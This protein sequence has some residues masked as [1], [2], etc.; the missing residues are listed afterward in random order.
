MRQPPATHC[1]NKGL[2]E[3]SSYFILYGMVQNMETV[4]AF[5]ME[6]VQT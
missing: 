2:A 5:F 3:T 4:D 6:A 1:E